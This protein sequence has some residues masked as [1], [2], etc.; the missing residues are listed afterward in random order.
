MNFTETIGV[1]GSIASIISII[2][3]IFSW[4][5]AN[6]A[7]QY[8]E[9]YYTTD[10]KEKL[11]T[12]FIR[13]ESIQE[14]SYKL[15]SSDKRGLNESNEIKEYEAIRQKLNNL[16]NIT[17]SKYSV[18]L[19][20]LNSIKDN[21]DSLIQKSTIMDTQD[22]ISFKTSINLCI[23]DVKSELE[24]LRKDLVDLQNK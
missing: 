13:L 3:A 7:K 21:I 18:I 5:K 2:G 4:Q 17:P 15:N 14:V 12:V 22:L 8:S 10:T 11:Q 6:Q 19:T 23:G 24:N 1:I 9:I 16:I 20:R